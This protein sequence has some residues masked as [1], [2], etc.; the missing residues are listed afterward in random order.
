[1]LIF[2]FIKSIL[3]VIRVMKSLKLTFV[4]R[5]FDNFFEK[6]ENFKLIKTKKNFKSYVN[7]GRV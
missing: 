6:T 4:K 2:K 7:K 1:M 5:F 3:D